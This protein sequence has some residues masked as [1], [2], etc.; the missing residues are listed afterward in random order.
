MD[1]VVEMLKQNF[2]A[3]IIG[4]FLV[5]AGVT[6]AADI[7]GAFSKM[8]GK[9]VKWVKKRD[10]DH[11]LL[12][13]TADSLVCLEKK[14]KEDEKKLREDMLQHVKE[15]KEEMEMFGRNRQSDREQSFKIQKE[16]VDAQKEISKAI[17]G[18]LHRVDKS[19][20]KQNKRVQAE[21]KDKISQL[22]RVYSQE[23]KI[24]KIELEALED[25]IAT[26]EEHGGINSFIHSKVQAEMYTWKITE[27]LV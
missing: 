1:S 26:Y 3:L 5:M 14:H 25:L 15:L 2:G 17:E 8:I 27:E 12:R 4:A 22:Y 11:E 13:K 10:T 23:K 9:P 18:I 19:E 21:I 20:R 16:L 7:I 24:S 6:K